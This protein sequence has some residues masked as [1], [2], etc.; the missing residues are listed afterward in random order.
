MSLLTD[1]ISAWEMD[2]ASGNRA[3]SHGSN[4]L[5]DVNTVGSGTGLVHGTAAD[6]E[7][8]NS[9]Q[10]THADNASLS[11]GD[12]DFTF[13]LWLKPETA[14]NFDSPISKRG[15]AQE[16]ELFLLSGGLDLELNGASCSGGTIT[17]GSWNH[18][19][20]W[21]DSTANELGFAINA[22]TPVTNT[23]GATVP[24]DNA[25]DFS[26]GA[27]AGGAGGYYDGLMGP[28]RFWKRMLT[29]GER[30][31]LYNAGAGLAYADLGGAAAGQ[32]AVK[33]MGGVTF[34]PGFAQ[35]VQGVRGW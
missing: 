12:I 16:Y 7:K 18:V 2:E 3:D 9:E 26:L 29:S 10:L 35:H 5:T 20:L 24:V 21:H 4:T 19:I 23:M 33:R 25:G 22:G 28:V 1:L 32:P 11:V 17:A 6:F 34:G 15:A 14:S 8:D 31:E 27:R 13:E 30:T